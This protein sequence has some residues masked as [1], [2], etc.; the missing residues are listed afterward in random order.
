MMMIEIIVVVILIIILYLI[1]RLI[2]VGGAG[3]AQWWEHSPPTDV[4]LRVV[5]LR[6]LRFSPPLKNQHFQILIR[7][8]FQWTNSHS[9][10]VPLQIPKFQIPNNWQP[11]ADVDLLKKCSKW[12]EL[13]KN[14]TRQ[15]SCYVQ[16][17]QRS[18][19]RDYLAQI[20]PVVRAGL[21]LGVSRFHS[22]PNHSTMHTAWSLRFRPTIEGLA[23]TLICLYAN[24]S[25][26][27]VSQKSRKRF[28][29]EKTFVTLRPAFS[30]KLGFS[31]VVKGINN[32]YNCKVSCPETPWFW[33]Y[34][35]N[36]VTRN[37]PEKFRDFCETDPWPH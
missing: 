26:G 14:P 9:V 21:E 24:T 2:I 34:K 19:A 7:S 30:V 17:Q 33:R 5:F 27:R 12:N 8:R 20:Q 32:H 31:Y 10:E 11:W 23:K 22:F 3:M 6:V 37:A 36:Y 29:P 1:S 15:T 25:F 18:W 4:A 13:V 35:E 28:E 16:V